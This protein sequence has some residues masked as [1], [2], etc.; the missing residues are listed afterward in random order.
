MMNINEVSVNFWLCL[1]MLSE[2]FIET[3]CI[4]IESRN[5]SPCYVFNYDLLY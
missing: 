3:H 1:V 4:Y 2:Y 5:L